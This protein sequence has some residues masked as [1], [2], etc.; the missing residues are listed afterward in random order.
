MASIPRYGLDFP[1][2]KNLHKANLH[3][4]LNIRNQ[5]IIFDQESS[6]LA[7][8]L[9]RIKFRAYSLSPEFKYKAK[10]G[11]LGFEIGGGLDWYFHYKQKRF[12]GGERSQKSIEF[13]Q[14]IPNPGVS[15]SNRVNQFN[16]YA[17]V[18]I[19]KRKGMGIYAEYYFL[20]D[21]L[22]SDFSYINA[23]GLTVKPYEGWKTQR[24]N[25]GIWVSL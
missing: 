13:A 7:G 12:E 9:D 22:N 17:R 16:P 21:F 8:S 6:T 10:L 5:G 24:L 18:A 23:V 4:G 14:W 11:K 15:N 1:F 2:I 25:L 20:K 3:A 19:G